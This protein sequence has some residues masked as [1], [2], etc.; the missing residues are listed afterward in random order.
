MKYGV[1]TRARES[2]G[3]GVAPIADVPAVVR[4]RRYVRYREG[5]SPR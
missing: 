1:Q 4:T 2:A 5:T 3:G